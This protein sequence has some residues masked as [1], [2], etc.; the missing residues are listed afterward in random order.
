MHRDGKS[1]HLQ[2]SISAES[3]GLPWHTSH[4]IAAGMLR[5]REDIE[6]ELGISKHS[7]HFLTVV[8][9]GGSVGAVDLVFG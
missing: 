8:A 7:G 3:V 1:M 5:R 6:L 4:G 2:P 9:R